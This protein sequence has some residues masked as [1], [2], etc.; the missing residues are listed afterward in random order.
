[1]S[2]I[3]NNHGAK[4]LLGREVK[5][6]LEQLGFAG[7]NSP[8]CLV[9]L[10]ETLI[11]LI[12]L[13]L[14]TTGINC[15]RNREVIHRGRCNCY[16]MLCVFFFF[17][18][19]WNVNVLAI[20]FSLPFPRFRG[21]KVII[22]IILETL[23]HRIFLDAIQIVP[24]NVYSV[25]KFLRDFTFYIFHRSFRAELGIF[26]RSPSSVS[27]FN[28]EKSGS[29][30]IS[31]SLFSSSFRFRFLHISSTHSPRSTRDLLRDCREDGGL[32]LGK[33]GEKKEK[34]GKE[35]NTR[36]KYIGSVIKEITSGGEN[37]TLSQWIS[38]SFVIHRATFSSLCVRAFV[39][40]WHMHTCPYYS[41]PS[42]G[43]YFLAVATETWQRGHAIFL[44]P[45]SGL[46]H[47]FFPPSTPPPSPPSRVDTYSNDQK[48]GI[49]RQQYKFILSFYVYVFVARKVE[50]KRV[51]FQQL[52]LLTRERE[53]ERE[54][55]KCSRRMVKRK[56]R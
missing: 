41:I 36:S 46:F 55:K 24:S 50:I 27:V 53:K 3:F 1:M 4:L 17:F 42:G 8:L 23:K 51:R 52:S 32:F 13:S 15:Y 7:W 2:V 28:L 11:T 45:S 47:A 22:I 16:S 43:F 40:V 33:R 20:D 35:K 54:F 21:R 19:F 49:H 9:Q 18:F 31:E 29:I 5:G 30:P 10:A 34:K 44:V 26:H 12:T 6:K 39:W 14:N 56:M 37:S 38:N 48:P 25:A